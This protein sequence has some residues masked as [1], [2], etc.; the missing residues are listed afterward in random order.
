MTGIS[1]K[2]LRV[3]IIDDDE[4]FRHTLRTTMEKAGCWV[5]EARN[6]Y[7]G[8]A[9]FKQETPDLVITD[10][11]MPYKE[12]LETIKEILEI[13]SGAKIIAMSSGGATHNMY[14]LQWAER[15]G[16]CGTLC[17]PIRPSDLM[18]K[19]TSVFAA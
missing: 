9:T 1:F 10:I 11:L 5:M 17:K 14:F 16:A 4:L 8:V 12:G 19:M 18:A 7:E 2:K 6:G 15:M 3:L 13:N